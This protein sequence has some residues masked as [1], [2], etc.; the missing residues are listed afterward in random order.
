MDKALINR[1]ARAISEQAGW[2]TPEG[3][4]FVS[5]EN[6]RATQFASAAVAAI[7]AVGEQPLF[8]GH[9]VEDLIGGTDPKTGKPEVTKCGQCLADRR[10]AR[11]AAPRTPETVLLTAP[12]DGVH[13]AAA[14]LVDAWGNIVASEEIEPY[15]AALASAIEAGKAPLQR[16]LNAPPLEV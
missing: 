5:S 16:T 8:C 13:R 14:A 10:A 6:P 7:R 4:D 11:D 12:D 3:Y 1:V 2:T 9:K 15:V